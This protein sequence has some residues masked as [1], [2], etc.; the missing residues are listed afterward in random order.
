MYHFAEDLQNLGMKRKSPRR[1]TE[2]ASVQPGKWG[3]L[4]RP[5]PGYSGGFQNFS[6]PDAGGAHPHALGSAVD[7]GTDALKVREPATARLVVRV[8]DIITA[9]RSFSANSANF[10]HSNLNIP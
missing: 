8:A 2:E 7:L 10:C 4:C 5:V 9:N 3:Q 6:L 1:V